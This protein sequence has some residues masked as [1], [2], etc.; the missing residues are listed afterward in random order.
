MLYQLLDAENFFDQ[1]E[2]VYT[3]CILN[4]EGMFSTKYKVSCRLDFKPGHGWSESQV[5]LDNIFYPE[6]SQ[7]SDSELEKFADELDHYF[8]NRQD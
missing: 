6:V 8:E 3:F 5:E 4:H 1:A 2:A 7:W